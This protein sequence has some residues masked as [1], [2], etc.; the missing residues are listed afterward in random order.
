MH[1]APQQLL[2]PT[3]NLPTYDS[4]PIQVQLDTNLRQD[5]K[6]VTKTE[7]YIAKNA[8]DGSEVA[9]ILF[10]STHQLEIDKYKH[11]QGEVLW[12]I[13]NGPG[14]NDYSLESQAPV[15]SQPQNPSSAGTNPP[16]PEFHGVARHSH[17]HP[18]AMSTEAVTWHPLTARGSIRGRGVRTQYTTRGRGWTRGKGRGG[19]ACVRRRY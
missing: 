11:S 7:G 16:P 15:Y 6:G 2:P 18:A 4:T 9:R 8:S 19:G 17:A 12:L 14:E 13:R 10:G 3:L 5:A 1:E